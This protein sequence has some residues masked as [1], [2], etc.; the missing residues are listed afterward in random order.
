M[1]RQDPLV[2]SIQALLEEL[3]VQ[4][5]ARVRRLASRVVEEVTYDDIFAPDDVP[6]LRGDP[7][8]MYED[9]L[10]AGI[11]AVQTAL[12]AHLR[13]IEEARDPLADASGER[14]G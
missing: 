12:R 3:A 1:T 9:G 7:D 14:D 11:L 8:Y 6:A 13:R 4:Q 5:E 2:L 10:L